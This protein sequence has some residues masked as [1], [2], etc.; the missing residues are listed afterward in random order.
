MAAEVALG[1]V[2]LQLAPFCREVRRVALRPRVRRGRRAHLPRHAA[3]PSATATAPLTGLGR[4][5]LSAASADWRRVGAI[6]Q[7]S[8]RRHPQLVDH[9]R[10]A[11]RA[12]RAEA[13]PADARLIARLGICRRSERDCRRTAA[14]RGRRPARP[15]GGWS[16]RC[17]AQDLV[18]PLAGR[19][20][21]SCQR[22]ARP[23]AVDTWAE[24]VGVNR[25]RPCHHDPAREVRE[26]VFLPFYQFGRNQFLAVALRVDVLPA[27]LARRRWRASGAR[28]GRAHRSRARHLRLSVHSRRAGDSAAPRF[29]A[30]VVERSRS[31]RCFSPASASTVVSYAVAAHPRDHLRRARRHHRRRRLVAS[32]GARR[33]RPPGG[34]AVWSALAAGAMAGALAACSSASPRATRA[35]RCSRPR[36]SG[37]GVGGDAA[38]RLAERS[39]SIPARAA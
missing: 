4:E 28:R 12:G 31:S 24:V 11:W 14:H 3:T 13:T 39:A 10:C 7:L 17:G 5:L 23:G 36:R 33:Y 2:L 1:V 32:Q 38:S 30:T 8:A 21:D 22:P 20:G 9:P 18:R 37:R 34:V 25:A 27:G 15:A 16:T 35:R 29:A 26:E 19:R 6:N